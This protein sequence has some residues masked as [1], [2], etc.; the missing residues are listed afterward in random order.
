MEPYCKHRPN[1]IQPFVAT[2]LLSP[3]VPTSSGFL[4]IYAQKVLNYEMEVSWNEGTPNHPI[5]IYQPSIINRSTPILGNPKRRQAT[6][7]N[8]PPH[9][10]SKRTTAQR[11]HH[12]CMTQGV[13][14]AVHCHVLWSMTWRGDQGMNRQ[15][16]AFSGLAGQVQYKAGAELSFIF[17]YFLSTNEGSK[18]MQQ[19]GLS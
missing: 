2:P 18:F 3:K 11:M 15:R 4:M 16:T 14:A 9:P 6:A 19:K 10:T 1:G 17:L 8:A 5:N 13:S 12:R 7:Q